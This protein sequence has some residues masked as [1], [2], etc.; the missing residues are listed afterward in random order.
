M[1]NKIGHVCLT[2]FTQKVFVCT[3]ICKLLLKVCV[4]K[5]ITKPEVFS[6]DNCYIY[7]VPKV[8]SRI[9][10]QRIII[11]IFSR[12]VKNFSR[13]PTFQTLSRWHCPILCPYDSF[14]VWF[15]RGDVRQVHSKIPQNLTGQMTLPR[16]R[17]HIMT[18]E[19]SKCGPLWRFRRHGEWL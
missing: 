15:S 5:C 4:D 6:V 3:K 1:Y 12:I 2:C 8:L 14:R 9:H 10:V 17:S 16:S 7:I 19:E 11:F 13:F 18:A